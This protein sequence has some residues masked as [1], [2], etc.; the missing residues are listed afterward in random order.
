[1]Q[2]IPLTDLSAESFAL[3][4]ATYPLSHFLTRACG[5]TSHDQAA[6][7]GHPDAHARAGSSRRALI[8]GMG[9]AWAA[10]EDSTGLCQPNGRP[11][12]SAP[13]CVRTTGMEETATIDVVFG[14]HANGTRR[15]ARAIHNRDVQH[16][17]R[18][19][20]DYAQRASG[21]GCLRGHRS[22]KRYDRHGRQ[23]NRGIIVD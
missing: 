16:D 2:G 21:C 20:A 11:T 12:V 5:C 23:F 14:L 19:R 7:R 10:L 13:F 18:K 17:S 22:G 4:I 6:V 3:P 15:H 9:P 8:G 1:M